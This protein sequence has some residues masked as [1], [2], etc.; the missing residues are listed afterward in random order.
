MSADIIIAISIFLLVY[1]FISTELLHRTIAAMVGASLFMGLKILSHEEAMDAVDWN[2]IFLLIGMMIIV[3]VTKKTGIFQYIAIKTAKLTKG[4]PFLILVSLSFITA[5]LSAFLD[6]VTTVLILTPISILI[7]EEL[8]IS[9][10]PFVVSEAI[11]S[12][13]GG[14]ATLI[15]D[16]PNLMIGSAAHLSFIDFIKNLGVFIIFLLIVMAGIL[17]LF[18]GKKL[19]APM[20][21]RARIMEFDERRTIENPKLLVKTA[22][23][24]TLT[25]LGFL[26]H[27]Y[28]D[29]QAASIAMLGASMLMLISGKKEVES[30]FEEVDFATIFFFIGLFI[31]VGGLV[32]LGVIKFLAN[33]FLNLTKGNIKSTSVLII[34][35]SGVF[36]AFVD[37]IPYVATMIPLIKDLGI[38]L[39]AHNIEPLWWALALGSCLGGNGTLVG[40]S[41]N[42][43]SAGILQKSGHKLSFWDFTKY[44][45]VI[46]FINLV[47]STIFILVFYF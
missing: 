23:I 39:G 26:I 44:G 20:R 13:I 35:I 31:L 30:F 42:V 21:A 18:F 41:A 33:L 1:I 24:L 10:I 32:K 28:L 8:E 34:W 46:T 40:A 6:N 37:N 4:E 29:L 47:F 25:I 15:G 2:V 19:H 11:A 9:P 3:G 17:Y 27:D 5:I 7:A 14:T 38:H 12:N 43:V 16:P 36:S 22:I 45:A